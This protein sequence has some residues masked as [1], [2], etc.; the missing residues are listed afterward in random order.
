[1]IAGSADSAASLAKRRASPPAS[2]PSP[3]PQHLLIHAAPLAVTRLALRPRAAIG[4][5]GIEPHTGAA[6]C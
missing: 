5:L 1:L 6:N 2:S 3:D 4:L